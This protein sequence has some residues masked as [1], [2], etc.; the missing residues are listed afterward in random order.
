MQVWE[1]VCRILIGKQW[2]ITRGRT[3]HERE[4]DIKMVLKEIR[5]ML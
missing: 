3:R 4:D 2:N 5:L 1:T